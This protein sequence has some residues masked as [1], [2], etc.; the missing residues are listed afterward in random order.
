MSWKD[1]ST[2]IHGDLTG[3]VFSGT[4]GTMPGMGGGRLPYISHVG[5]CRPKGWGFCTVLV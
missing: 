3:D 1:S 4:M 5:M 2:C